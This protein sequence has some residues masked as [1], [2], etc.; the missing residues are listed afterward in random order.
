MPQYTM[1]YPIFE[2]SDNI[3]EEPDISTGRENLRFSQSRFEEHTIIH[4]LLNED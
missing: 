3:G 2:P 1:C 4:E